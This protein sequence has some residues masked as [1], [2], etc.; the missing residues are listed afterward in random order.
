MRWL[1]ILL[2]AL[3]AAP[4]ALAQ[5]SPTGGATAS[6]LVQQ[7]RQ[8]LG[9]GDPQQARRLLEEA[10]ARDSKSPEAWLLLAYCY[11]SLHQPEEAERFARRAL[12]GGGGEPALLA[13]ANIL[14]MQ[15]RDLEVIQLLEARQAEF[16]SSAKYLFTLGLSHYHNGG[17]ARATELFDRALALDPSLAQAHYLEGNA[18]ARLGKPELALTHY[19]QAVR[20]APQNS[21]YSFQLGQLHSGL[22]DKA[23]A[24]AELRRSVELDPSYAQARYELAK[25]YFESSRDDAAREQ[26]ERAIRSDAKFDGSYYLLSQVYAR[27]GRPEDA[28]RMLKQFQAIKRHRQEEQRALIQKSAEGPKP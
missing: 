20:L 6:E 21:L 19:Q 23:R 14:Q 10:V 4:L 27:L 1:A 26:L 5:Q 24:E 15:G 11:V 16:S 22:G 2:C 28:Q 9:K 12:A 8:A 13:L 25:I 18:L 17:Y 3:L 7:A